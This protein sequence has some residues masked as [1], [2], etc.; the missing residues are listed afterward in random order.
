MTD[1]LHF[2]KL[3][4][5]LLFGAAC[6]YIGH[7]TA[8]PKEQRHWRKIRNKLAGKPPDDTPKLPLE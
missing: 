6:F 4:E 3:I 5:M 2:T 1:L 8:K 7:Q